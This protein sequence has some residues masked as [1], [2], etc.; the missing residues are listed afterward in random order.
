MKKE[1]EGEKSRRSEDGMITNKY[2]R[3]EQMKSV[4][5]KE[6]FE[7]EKVSK[8]KRRIKGYE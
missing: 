6:S 8:S 7:E 2:I 1:G 5:E 4:M 3:K